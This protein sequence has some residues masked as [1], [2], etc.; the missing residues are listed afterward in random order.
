MDRPQT[1]GEEIANAVSHGV[2]T[3]AAIVATPFLIYAAATKGTTLSI[4]GVSIFCATVI[5]LYLC[6]TIYHSLPR[7][8]AKR[9]FQIFDHMSIF[10]LIAGTYTPFT[11]GVLRGATGWTLFGLIWGTAVFGIITKMVPRLRHS[12]LSLFL[13][14]GMGWMVVLVLRPLWQSLPLSHFLWLVAGGVAYTAGVIFY[15]TDNHVRYGHFVWHLFT[16]TGTVCH[17]IAIA[18]CI[19]G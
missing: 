2:G 3:L 7:N 13:Y 5:L 8:Q 12:P 15:A 14:L 9:L 6:S 10:L 4:V 1:L 18:L 16:I 17:F 11:F 19:A